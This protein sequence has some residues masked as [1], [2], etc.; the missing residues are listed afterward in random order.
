MSVE[1]IKLYLLTGF[2][3]A[4]K[5]TLLK[6]SIELLSE[7]KLGI[8]MNE[9]GNISVDG[10]LLQKNGIDILEINNG[11]VFCSCLKGTFINA[12]IAYSELPIEYLF[13]ESSGM[14]DP[15][16][17]RQILTDVVGKVKGK[18]YDYRGAV[19]IVDGVHF[20]DQ[21]D[22]LAAIER[23]I[24]ASNLIVINKVDLI[25]A[26]G[27]Q[28]VEERI[29]SINP[30][31]ELLATTYCN[32]GSG[33]LTHKLK[34]VE[35][36]GIEESCNTPGNRPTAHVVTAREAVKRSD[37]AEFLQG[38]APWTLRMKGFFRLDDGWCQVDAVG[39]RVEIKTTDI[40]RSASELVVISD[41]GLPALREIYARWDA[42]FPVE[43][44]VQ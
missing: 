3:G 19:C 2:L 1:P 33:F 25:D 43:M 38:I 16:N 6:N 30:Q 5:T 15:S 27:L 36:N 9:F 7:K 18:K 13:V 11:S 23:Q 31:A 21:L 40:S 41:K 26:A 34:T 44:S 42:L 14:A 4:G 32:I 35:F 10:V 12:L 37:F 17:I 24:A 39:E 8:L 28:A 22:V 20:L 29:V